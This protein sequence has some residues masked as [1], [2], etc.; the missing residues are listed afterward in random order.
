VVGVPDAYHYN[1]KFSNVRFL[2]AK[3]TNITYLRDSMFSNVTFD[4]TPNPWGITKSN[5]LTFDSGTTTTPVTIDATSAP[6][7]SSGALTATADDVS[8]TLTWPVAT[9]N[10]AVASYRV[11][12]GDTQIASVPGGTTSYRVAGLS[13]AL[14]YTFKVVAEDASGNTTAGPTAAVTTTGI[15]DTIPPTSPIE[16]AS[17][18]LS[19]GSLGATWAKVAWTP[20][21]DNFG[22]VR[23]DIAANGQRIGS[24]PADTTTY[25]ATRLTPGA[26]YVFTITAVDAAG[27]ATTY[28]ATLQATTNPR[29][30]TA[31]PSWPSGS[32]LTVVATT[33][34]SVTLSWTAAT[35]DVGVLGYRVY[36]NDR[37]VP[38]G[39]AFTPASVNSTATTTTYTVTG[40]APNT[41]MVLRVEA[42]DATGRWSN[43]GPTVWTQTTS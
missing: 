29:Y 38:A 2:H 28:P 36:A 9:D 39:L 41:G 37:L 1:I 33:A 8:A 40:L 24:V 10:V 11:Y 35:D 20:A 19:A 26:A 22:V 18:S 14:P 23:Y 31:L 4:A 25:T 43:R 27:N 17:I 34:T 6:T 16:P 3:P 30:D 15:R 21:A 32:T 12:N 5:R 42:G 7:W 13:P